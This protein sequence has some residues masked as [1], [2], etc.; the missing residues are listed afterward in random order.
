MRKFVKTIVGVT[1]S[2]TTRDGTP[3][4]LDLSL[5]PDNLALLCLRPPAGTTA[6]EVRVAANELT[7]MLDAILT[8][9]AIEIRG[10][11]PA[12]RDERMCSLRAVNRCLRLAA[13]APH[14]PDGGWLL[15]LNPREFVAVL[16][17]FVSQRNIDV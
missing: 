1:I 13:Y 15:D 6:F 4:L 7:A 9:E 12:G 11:T 17:L 8:G 5:L 16:N 3:R 14:N 2:G 10:R